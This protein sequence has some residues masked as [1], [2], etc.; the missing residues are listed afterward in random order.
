MKCI[1]LFF[2][3]IAFYVSQIPENGQPVSFATRE[4]FID[5]QTQIDTL[6]ESMQELSREINILKNT[7][8]KLITGFILACCMAAL[9]IGTLAMSSLIVVFV[10][11]RGFIRPELHENEEFREDETT[12]LL[13]EDTP[14]PSMISPSYLNNIPI[15]NKNF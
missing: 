9:S 15:E 14:P 7:Q 1:I 8:N 3:L 5:E 4:V 12:S 2:I 13:E 6:H 11:F 10:A